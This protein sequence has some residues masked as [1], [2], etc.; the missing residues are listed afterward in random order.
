MDCKTDL[1]WTFSRIVYSLLCVITWFCIS[2]LLREVN[3]R[4]FSWRC[5]RLARFSMLLRSELIKRKLLVA[6]LLEESVIPINLLG[7]MSLSSTF[8]PSLNSPS[9][10][11]TRTPSKAVNDF[12]PCQLMWDGHLS[13]IPLSPIMNKSYDKNKNNRSC[14][15]LLWPKLSLRQLHCTHNSIKSCQNVSYL[16]KTSA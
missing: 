11:W 4:T 9:D 15:S 3:C 13:C 8:L 5:A 16:R 1:G 10:Y 7:K 2:L 6:F 14:I 12:G